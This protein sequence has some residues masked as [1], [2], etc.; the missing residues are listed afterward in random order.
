MACDA[1]VVVVSYA[2]AYYLLRWWRSDGSGSTM[3]PFHEYLWVLWIIEPGWVFAFWKVSLCKPATYKTYRS[4]IPAILKGQFLG[5]LLLL[6]T[7]YLTKSEYISRLLLNGFLIV[8]GAGL[9]A[10][11]ISLKALLDHHGEHF[12]RERLWRVLLIGDGSEADWYRRFVAEH[13]HWGIVIAGT[14]SP[15]CIDQRASNGD[16]RADWER[17]ITRHVIDEVVAVCPRPETAIIDTLVAI[18]AERGI[19]FRVVV[20]MPPPLAGQYFIDDIGAGSYVVSLEPIPQEMLQLLAK[21]ALDIMGAAAGL[22]LCGLVFPFYAAWLKLVSPGP[23]LFRQE[24]LGRNG[25]RFVMYKFRTM[26][27]DADHQLANLL[28]ANQ[29][30]GAIF[31]IHNDP[32]IIR[33][34]HFMRG[35]HLDELPQFFNV[36]KGDMSLVGTRPPTP[37]EAEQYQP[38]HYRRLSMR[39]GITGLWQLSGNGTVTDFDEVVRL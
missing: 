26:C 18:C 16:F 1:L 3:G 11:K 4:L 32:R 31:K 15:G 37:R 22:V 5:G 28:H 8:S 33:G 2:A 30:S 34:G 39:P 36:L 20:K 38:H 35:T 19:T 12:R 29:M 17:V 21:R 10:E 9:V 6:S 24:R 25:R 14:E 23:V 13:Q 27:P 7:M